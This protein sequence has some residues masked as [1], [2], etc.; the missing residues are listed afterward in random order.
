MNDE[1]CAGQLLA[2][3]ESV[4]DCGISRQVPQIRDT[5]LIVDREY[6]HLVDIERSAVRP[7]GRLV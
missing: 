7:T 5:S 1:Q 3:E 6:V 2:V 4:V